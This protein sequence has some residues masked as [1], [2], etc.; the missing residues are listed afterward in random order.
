MTT[1]NMTRIGG[2]AMPKHA[3]DDPVMVGYSSP[4][5]ISMTGKD[6]LGYTWGEFREMS[7]KEQ[8]EAL[9]DFAN[10]LIDVYVVEDEN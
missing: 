5:N 1:S 8:G 3:D 4:R 10:E 2:K 9:Q 6:E 7:E